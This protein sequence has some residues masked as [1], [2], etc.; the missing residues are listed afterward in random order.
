[1]KI[2]TLLTLIFTLVFVGP[3]SAMGKPDNPGN[4]K[5]G[6]GNNDPPIKSVCIDAGHGGTDI[7]TS[8]GGILEKDLNLAVAF[9]LQELLNTDGYSTYMT[10]EDNSTL[11]NNDRYTFCNNM[12]TSTLVSI[13]HNGSI[14]KS[15]DYTL[16]LYHQKKSRNLARIVGQSVADEFGQGGTFRIDRFPSGVL[17]KS[18]MPSM[19]SEGYFLTNT[20]RLHELTSDYDTAV[21]KEAQSLLNGLN[22]YY[23]N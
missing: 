9:K 17:I 10:R 19:I 23:N 16:G 4:G 14:D 13:H 20:D 12:N 2:F 22:S 7:G 3:V 5:P 21:D 6:G 15:V 18:D 1:M 11:S 8:N